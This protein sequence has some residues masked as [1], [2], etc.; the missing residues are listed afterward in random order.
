MLVF[1]KNFGYS[2]MLQKY[3]IKQPENSV[4]VPSN[5]CVIVTSLVFQFLCVDGLEWF[6]PF[7][8]EGG[9]DS[10]FRAVGLVSSCTCYGLAD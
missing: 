8:S 4:R 10:Y 5:W 7:L 9:R 2:K 6:G 3:P 1:I